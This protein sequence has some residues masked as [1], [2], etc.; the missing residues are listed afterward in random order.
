MVMTASLAIGPLASHADARAG[1]GGS[2]GSRGSRTWSAPPR[3]STSPYEA[4]PM[5][6]SIAPRMAP[7]TPGYG[8]MGAAPF[9]RQGMPYQNRHPFLTG[10]A[11]GFLGAGLF[12]LLSG[13]GFMGGV[14]GLF[15]FLGLL[16]QIGLVV[17]VVMW[18]VRRFSGAGNRMGMGAQGASG[19]ASPPFG[20][21]PQ[22]AST[23]VQIMP[24]DYQ[25]FQQTLLDI[26]TAWNQQNIS[27]M[28]Q[29]ATPEMVSYFNEQLATLASQGA[30]NVVSDVRF[31]QGDL[32]EAWS[33]N[34]MNYATVAMRYSLI[35]L[36]TNAMGQVIDGSST[37]PVTITELWT[38]VRPAR[39]GRWLLSAIQQTR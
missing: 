11:G 23:P 24:A 38:F 36:T 4:A 34:G 32:S 13:H 39:G 20:A 28:Q 5:E 30:R 31:L 1:S 12:G 17:M 2:M 37:D 35:D 6:R 25:A 9:A 19:P 10:F 16:I 8:A 14:G 29:M 15:S 26:Q 33:E 27:A 18:L 22:P 7:S 3:T 21:Q